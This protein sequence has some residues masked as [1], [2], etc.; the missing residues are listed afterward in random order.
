MI[1]NKDTIL[2]TLNKYNINPQDCII[3]SGAALVLQ[4]IKE[5]TSD[6]D[7]TISKAQYNYLLKKYN[8]SFE[9]EINNYKIWIID[10]IINFS[11][12]YYEDIEYIEL[13]GYKVQSI[14]S[15]LKLKQQLNRS[16]DKKDIQAILEFY[17]KTAKII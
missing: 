2:K 3:I 16:K 14:D 13:F 17:K 5:S 11:N 1:F 9:K 8:C 6:I 15:I 7:L 12:H 4:N 10:N